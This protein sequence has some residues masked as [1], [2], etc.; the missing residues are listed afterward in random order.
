VVPSENR[1]HERFALEIH[2]DEVLETTDAEAG[3]SKAACIARI[4]VKFGVVPRAAVERRR[5]AEHLVLLVA[6]LVN[7]APEVHGRVRSDLLKFEK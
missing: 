7:F 4:P 6:G 1:E 5:I 3:V 2:P